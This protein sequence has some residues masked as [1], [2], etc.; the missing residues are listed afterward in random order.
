M[1]VLYKP[2]SLVFSLIGA[3]AAKKLFEFIWSLIDKEDPP[4]AT[5]RD[6]SWPKVLGAAAVEGATFK[7]TR[8]AVD[9]AGARSFER[10]TGVW[11]GPS[12]SAEQ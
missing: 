7:M 12:T 3:F 1:G 4:D 6:A 5:V 2:L 11:P 10:L 9:R 8:A